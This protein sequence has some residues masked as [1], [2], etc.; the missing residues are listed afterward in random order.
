LFTPDGWLMTG[1]LGLLK[2]GQLVVTGRKKD[3]LIINGQN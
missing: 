3:L 2:N 1:D